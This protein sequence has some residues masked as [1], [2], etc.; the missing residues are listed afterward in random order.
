MS[1]RP[2]AETG[3][4]ARAE[5]VGKTE[6]G[7]VTR[8]CEGAARADLSLVPLGEF[9]RETATGGGEEPLQYA[10]SYIQGRAERGAQNIH[11]PAT[12]WAPVRAEVEPDA[13]QALQG[14]HVMRVILSVGEVADPAQNLPHAADAVGEIRAVLV[15]HD[16]LSA[17]NS[18]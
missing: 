2:A 7:G 12:R 10:S 8:T 15:V 3:C 14:G 18:D 16:T 9:R 4:S 6:G 11:T 5:R 17:I 13:V 1:T